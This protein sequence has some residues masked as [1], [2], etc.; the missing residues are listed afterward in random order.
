[1]IFKYLQIFYNFYF[2]ILMNQISK[3]CIFCNSIKSCFSRDMR[4]KDNLSKKCNDCKKLKLPNKN[5]IT[6][7]KSLEK[8]SN[9]IDNLSN[10]NILTKK[11]SL[12][13]FFSVSN[14]DID[15]IQYQIIIKSLQQKVEMAIQLDIKKQK[16][17]N[18]LTD[19]CN[20][21]QKEIKNL[22]NIIYKLSSMI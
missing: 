18:F 21:F 6:K 3:M 1:M 4:C 2:T 12:E 8:I 10:K 22:T 9:N 16:D 13:R 17:I 19:Q 7:K 20:M 5:I 14:H 15:R 11:K